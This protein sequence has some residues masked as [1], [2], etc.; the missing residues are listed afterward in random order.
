MKPALAD[1]QYE[2]TR[3]S[4]IDFFCISTTWLNTQLVKLKNNELDTQDIAWLLMKLDMLR[5]NI[6]SIQTMQKK[7]GEKI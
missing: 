5:E 1:Y 4:H 2:K 6:D 3:N 7:L